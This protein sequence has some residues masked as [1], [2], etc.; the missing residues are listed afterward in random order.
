MCRRDERRGLL[1]GRQQLQ[2]GIGTSGAN[3]S[4]VPVPVV[5][6]P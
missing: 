4:T 6:F 5:G 2:L 1:L 3:N